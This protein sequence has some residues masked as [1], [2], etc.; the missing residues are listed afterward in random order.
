MRNIFIV[1]ATQAVVSDVHPE[2][3]KSNV[4]GYPK[5]QDSR[6]YPAADGNPNGDTDK[7]LINAQSDFATAVKDLTNANNPARVMWT[8]TLEQANGVQIARKSWGAFPDLTP[9]AP[10]PEPEP[11]EQ[12]PA[13]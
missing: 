4:T 3:V 5:E 7:A 8:V 2:G 12:E 10:E 11:I 13:E 1:N 6:S 9:P